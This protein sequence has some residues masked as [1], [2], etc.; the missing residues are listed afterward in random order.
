VPTRASKPLNVDFEKQMAKSTA[1]QQSKTARA[2]TPRTLPPP[3]ESTSSAMGVSRSLKNLTQSSTS[4]N[5]G[6]PKPAHS[7]HRK[8][9]KKNDNLPVSM[10]EV[11]KD[12]LKQAI[13]DTKKLQDEAGV[14]SFTH[15]EHKWVGQ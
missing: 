13:K 8:D 11:Y 14:K 4:G 9:D 5:L 6:A 7:K 12:F 1:G 10:M 15:R 2:V 3:A